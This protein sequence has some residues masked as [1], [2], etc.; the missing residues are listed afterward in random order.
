MD[1]DLAALQ[2][3]SAAGSYW[4]QRSH[5]AYYRVARSL[6]QEIAPRARSILD[7]GSN[8][9]P[10]LDWFE[11]AERKVSV[12]LVTPYCGPGVEAVTADF[13]RYA[14]NERFDV[15][16][17]LQVLEHVANPSAFARKLLS[18]ADHVIASVPY[19][20]PA[21]K[22]VAHLHD[23]VDEAKM[24]EWFGREPNLSIIVEEE[25]KRSASKRLICHYASGCRS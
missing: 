9:C 2:D 3:N 18:L 17:C 16:L 19:R 5:F 23:P 13:F 8:G 25:K 6:A 15:C 22:C 24:R 10:H 11:H 20:W 4:E 14:T 1:Q 21:G 12:D 7:V